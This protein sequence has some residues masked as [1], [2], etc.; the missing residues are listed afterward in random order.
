[1]F[2]RHLLTVHVPRRF[3]STVLPGIP[4]IRIFEARASG[5]PLVSAPW[6]GSEGLFTPGTDF[7]TAAAGPAMLARLRDLQHDAALRA[8]LAA[9]GL[10]TIRARHTCSH[11]ADE[12]LG[13][14]ATLRQPAPG[15]AMVVSTLTDIAFYGSSLLSS[16]WNGAAT[17]YRGILSALAPLGHRI[18]CDQPDAFDRQRHRDIEPPDYARVVVYP[19]TRLGPRAVLDEAPRADVVVKASGVNMF[20]E[21]LLA[22]VLDRA[23]PGAL[24][25][26]W[27]VDAAATLDE[28]RANPDHPM[29]ALL[30]RLDAV[31]TYGGGPPVVDAYTALGARVCMPIYNAL[32]RATHH[33]VRPDPRFTAGLAFLAK[34]LPD[35]ERRAEQFFPDAAARCPVQSFLLGG[36]GW[37]DKAMPG[38]IRAI[39]HVG[40]VDH[41][42]FNC[43]AKVVLNV[44]RGSMAQVGFSPATRVFEAARGGRVPDHRRLG[45]DRAVPDT[46]RGGARGAGRGGSAGGAD[47]GAGCHHGRGGAAARRRVLAGHAYA[48]RAVIVDRLL[49]SGFAMAA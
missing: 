44:A 11:R 22:G 8:A 49:R 45:R 1:M 20:D 30:P 16:H 13:I 28:V 5:I 42:A 21:E 38:N 4:T 2:A 43:S 35:R 47:A 48:Q 3:H 7:L 15:H 14:V 23:R 40:T 34:R 33:S 27:D 29:R 19:V 39:G 18:T 10:A 31:L 41:N 37:Y 6:Q 26:F 25:I 9:H 46:R 17:Y 36:T 24:R 12:L 32:D